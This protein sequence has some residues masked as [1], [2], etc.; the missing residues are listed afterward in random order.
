M[1]SIQQAAQAAVA[2]F[3]TTAVSTP[4]GTYPLRVVM[5]AIAGRE[6][7]W[8][9][10]AAGDCGD[11]GP[12]CGS[13]TYGGSGATSWGLWQ[14]H[15]VH[16]AYLTR[17]THSTNPCTWKQW[18]TD[19][20]NNA[21]AARSLYHGN[22]STFLG[23]WSSWTQQQYVPYLGQAALA[24]RS[25]ETRTTSTTTPSIKKT[26]VILIPLALMAVGILGVGADESWASH[27][28]TG[29]WWWQKRR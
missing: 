8:N 21:Q 1:S 29:R 17:Q 13:C 3:P 24:V 14:I 20:L 6:S 5:V 7:G 16:S 27:N 22:L 23:N 12:A 4:H 25:A 26:P 10:S 19:P 9:P 2:V 11:S 28:M 15:N 18:L